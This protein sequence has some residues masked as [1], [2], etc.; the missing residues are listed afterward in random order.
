VN[1]KLNLI[2]DDGKGNHN[3]R[4][5]MWCGGPVDRTVGRVA[6]F[7]VRKTWIRYTRFTAQTLARCLL[8]PYLGCQVS[9]LGI[10]HDLSPPNW[11]GL[12]ST[13]LFGVV[14]VAWVNRWA[15]RT[16]E[17]NSYH[18]TLGAIVTA[19]GMTRIRGIL[20]VVSFTLGVAF[21]ATGSG[22][23][24]SNLVGEAGTMVYG[25]ALYCVTIGRPEPPAKK[26]RERTPWRLPHLV[27]TR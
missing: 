24:A 1:V 3:R 23:T 18:P 16:S 19:Y 20:V 10:Q 5:F 27:P 8:A 13:I 26:V 14:I 6:F 25:L 15:D 21:L 7:V 4:A 12:A 2:H 9:E 11:F 17:L 22:F